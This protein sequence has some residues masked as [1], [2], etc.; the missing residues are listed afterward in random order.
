MERSPDRSTFARNDAQM[1]KSQPL[2]VRNR[3]G[4]WEVFIVDDNRWLACESEDDA[5]TI[6]AAAGL[7]HVSPEM[8][9]TDPDMVQQIRKASA[10]FSKYHMS[11]GSELLKHFAERADN[12]E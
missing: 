5:R 10:T 2:P 9:L 7:M 3:A 6:A 4:K 1:E 12:D 8:G 11:F